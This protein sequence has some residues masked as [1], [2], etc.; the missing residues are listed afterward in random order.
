MLLP[1]NYLNRK[2]AME[3][4][5]EGQAIPFIV[6]KEGEFI[7]TPEAQDFLQSLSGRQIGVVCVVGKYRT[8]K[9]Y[10]INK[11][12]LQRTNKDGFKVGP[13]VNPCTKVVLCKAGSMDLEPDRQIDLF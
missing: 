7:V 4:K 13:T 11:V 8:G 3:E 10:L 9:S 2:A 5:P 1:V 6:S 12:I